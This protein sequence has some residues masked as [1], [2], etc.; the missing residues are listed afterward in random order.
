M[1]SLITLNFNETLILIPI[2]MTWLLY[3]IIAT[4]ILFIVNYWELMLYLVLWG[5][6]Q[7]L[8]LLLSVWGVL[9]TEDLKVLTSLSV[10][11]I[12]STN[13]LHFNMNLRLRLFSKRPGYS[14]WVEWIASPSFPERINFCI[15]VNN[16]WEVGRLWKHLY[17][18][19]WCA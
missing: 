18:D 7:G 8:D 16:M 15:P 11:L 4:C 3:F 14:S 1:E 10:P 13:C 2:H 5:D 6:I 9:C 12:I 17:G 19:T